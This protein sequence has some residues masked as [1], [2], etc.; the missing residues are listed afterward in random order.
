[1]SLFLI[2]SALVTGTGTLIPTKEFHVEKDESGI[3]KVDD[4]GA[5]IKGRAVDRALAYLAH[6]ESPVSLGPFFGAIFGTIYDVSTILILW[7]AGA[8]A[9]GR[10]LY[11]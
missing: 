6:G 10:I 7:F 5:E 3:V 8:S 9:M 4:N 1:M 2:G 11:G